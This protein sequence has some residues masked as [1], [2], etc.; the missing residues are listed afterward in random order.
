MSVIDCNV[1]FVANFD[2]HNFRI[3]ISHSQTM[4]ANR[5]QCRF[6]RLIMM[7]SMPSLYVIGQLSILIA[8]ANVNCICSME[9]WMRT[10]RLISTER[11]KNIRIINVRRSK[12]IVINQM[13]INSA[14]TSSGQVVKLLIMPYSDCRFGAP[15]IRYS[16]KA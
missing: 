6:I 15:I 12:C 1:S 13:R 9:L 5:G 14:T 7:H 10:F 2:Q 8:A 16:T 11:Q 3:M 4:S